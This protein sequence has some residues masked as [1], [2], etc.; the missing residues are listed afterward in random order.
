MMSVCFLMVAGLVNANII[1]YQNDFSGGTPG[2]SI[3]AEG[4][5]NATKIVYG[6]E[7]DGAAGMAYRQAA[8]TE[9]GNGDTQG[10]L[11]L[12]TPQNAY[13]LSAGETVTMTADV[14][15]T[16]NAGVGVGFATKDNLYSC[17]TN[18]NG[19]C[20]SAIEYSAVETNP[21]SELSGKTI[22][23]RIALTQNS[24]TFAMKPAG[25]EWTSLGS[26]TVN[27]T[28]IRCLALLS[29]FP[30]SSNNYGSS[31]KWDNIVVTS[32]LPEPAT[33]GL[34]AMGGLM[35]LRKKAA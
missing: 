8:G 26:R 15:G 20:V 16:G 23:Y 28:Q 21:L 27:E 14:V 18:V 7:A 4:W 24:V 2:T 17:A 30:G 12:L 34:L 3:S 10:L 35:F 31:F 25:G 22:T 1:L 6:S 32:S 5:S 13:I 9:Y 19:S 11:N 33:I 29:D